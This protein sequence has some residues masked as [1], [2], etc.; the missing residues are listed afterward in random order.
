LENEID[1]KM[2]LVQENLNRLFDTKNLV[3]FSIN[4]DTQ[5]ISIDI[6]EYNIMIPFSS[7]GFSIYQKNRLEWKIEVLHIEKIR[8]KHLTAFTDYYQSDRYIKE[9]VERLKEDR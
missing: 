8:N 1:K 2:I 7:F 6:K 3:S 4:H 5:H 9:V